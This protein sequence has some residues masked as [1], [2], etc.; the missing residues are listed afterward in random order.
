MFWDRCGLT[1]YLQTALRDGRE[2][3]H[4]CYYKYEN[5]FNWTSLKSRRNISFI[6]ADLWDIIFN[7][8]HEVSGC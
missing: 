4:R 3:L 8:S 5:P 6:E 2:M 7:K 1:P